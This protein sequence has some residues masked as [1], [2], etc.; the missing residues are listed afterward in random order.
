MIIFNDKKD[1]IFMCS[2]KKNREI[3]FTTIQDINKR[4]VSRQVGIFGAGPIAEK[5]FRLLNKPKQLIIIDNASNLW[6]ETQFGTKIEDPNEYSKDK[7][8][9]KPFIVICSTS[10]NE[11][12]KQLD[13]MGY[14]S[15][16]D[17]SVSPILNDLR[18]IDELE[19]V[20]S[21]ILF[22]SGSPE[23][24]S[25][26]WGGGVYELIVTQDTW[27]H[28]KVISGNIYGMIKYSK[29]FLSVDTER[30]IIEFDSKYNIVRSKIL[31]AGMR[32]HGIAFSEKHEK[33]FVVGSH[34]DGVLV[35]DKNFNVIDEIHLSFKKSRYGQPE[36]HCNDCLIVDDSLY[37]SMFSITGNYKRDVF[38]GGVLE[39]DIANNQRVG[40]VMDHLWMPHNISLIDGSLHILDSLRG[41]LRTNNLSV[42]G[43]FPAFSRGLAYDGVYYYIGQS[44]NRNFSKNIGLSKNI[45]IDAGIIIFDINTKVSRFLQLPPKLSEIHSI[46][47]LD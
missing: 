6:G 18:I 19:S 15:A 39:Y 10:F 45:S 16:E 20:S 2:D 30:G 43:E 36:H 34:L 27:E 28:R 22:S 13:E 41:Q 17:Y 8:P 25:D 21:K 26:K 40:Q 5:T 12:S 29:N 35:L 38:D 46:I 31:P 47:I 1:S 44:R 23:G 24:D 7:I 4:I 11:I 14:V 3:P 42:M 32:A 33:I 9:V 37:V